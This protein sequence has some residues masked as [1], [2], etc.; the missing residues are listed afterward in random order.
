MISVGAMSKNVLLHLHFLESWMVSGLSLT[1]ENSVL[2]AERGCACNW[3]TIYF[4]L[5]A[6]RG[7]LNLYLSLLV[8]DYCMLFLNAG[9]ET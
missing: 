7:R 9:Q 8:G 4:Y 2:V 1:K 6:M 5:S 3:N